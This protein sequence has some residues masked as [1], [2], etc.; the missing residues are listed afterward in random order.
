MKSVKWAGRRD[1]AESRAM[2]MAGGLSLSVGFSAGGFRRGWSETGRI[3]EGFDGFD[4]NLTGKLMDDD[5]G[6]VRVR[7]ALLAQPWTPATNSFT[8]G[9]AYCQRHLDGDTT[10]RNHIRDYEGI[11]KGTDWELRGAGRQTLDRTARG[12]GR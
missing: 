11:Y 10:L 5:G 1:R 8:H 7:Q 12:V 4:A 3:G 6:R 9:L 2:E